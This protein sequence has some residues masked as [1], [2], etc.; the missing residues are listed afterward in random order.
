MQCAWPIKS[1]RLSS[2]QFAPFGPQ[3]ESAPELLVLDEPTRDLDFVRLAALE[4][5]LVVWSGGLLVVS[6]DAEFLLAI[7]V[8]RRRAG[9]FVTSDV[10]G[11]RPTGSAG[12][13]R[14]QTPGHFTRSRQIDLSSA[15]TQNRLRSSAARRARG[16]TPEGSM[17]VVA[18]PSSATRTSVPAAVET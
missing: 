17:T 6:H 15:E 3:R 16:W 12:P 7:G 14:L 2:R 10:R 11:S 18:P 8:A 9:T 1:S 5:V 4:A 13:W